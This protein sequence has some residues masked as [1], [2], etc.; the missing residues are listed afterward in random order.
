MPTQTPSPHRTVP[1]FLR[2]QATPSPFPAPLSHVM[3]TQEEEGLMVGDDPSNKGEDPNPI[4]VKDIQ[5]A[6]TQTALHTNLT[7]AH[8]CLRF[9]HL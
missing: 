6:S 3:Y 8:L 4:S 1:L 7:P 2:A 5:V 9:I